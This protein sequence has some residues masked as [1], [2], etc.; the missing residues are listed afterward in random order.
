LKRYFGTDGVR[1]VA[2]SASGHG[3]TAEFALKLGQAAGRWLQNSGGEPKVV[4]GRDTRRSGPMLEGAL[5]AGFNSVG[6]S[7]TNLGV[8][9][10]PA[11]A[12][13][14]RVGGFGLGGIVSASHNPAED[15]GI[16]FVDASG[17][18]LPDTAEAEIEALLEQP[19]DRPTGGALGASEPDETLIQRYLAHLEAIVPERLHGLDIA[20]D[21]AH[22]AAYQLGPE[23]LRRLG[24]TVRVIG[25]HPNG[26][27]INAEGG[28]T[29]PHAISEFTQA[30]KA[31]VGIAFDGDA[32]RAIACDHLGRLINGDR[33]MAAW[34]V[35]AQKEGRLRVPAVVGTVMSN[36]GLEH[37]LQANAIKLER[38]DVGDKY[39]AERLKEL[40]GQIGGEQ[41]GHII[42]PAHGPTGDGLATM[43][44]FL[45]VLQL[46][47]EPAS[48]WV[49][50]YE[51]WPQLLLNLKV[52]Q[53]K[54]FS[55][56]PVVVDAIAEAQSSL[57]GKGRVNVRASG[58][59]P[60]LR[61]MVEAESQDDR[62][63]WAARI[64]AA[65]LQ[66]MGGEVVG[67]VD[68]THSL[69]D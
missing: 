57:E 64:E 43:L 55:S 30:T 18:K 26:D 54:T 63:S 37:F 11:V 58:T 22:G 49:D 32:D 29:K 62:D 53:P 65:I 41:S 39:V 35:T 52:E 8:A 36:G 46:T 47:G 5:A 45:R 19:F 15:N 20:V 51:P 3:L 9:P 28:A 6:V 59:Q 17:S 16:K 60:V 69:G 50:A 21:A 56:R 14:A 68:L 38:T 25:V 24:A 66:S 33:I 2:N 1:G 44:E 40:G 13:A 7:V 48:K 4:L 12:F 67:R 42:F 27:N 10:T 61:V 23:V 34:A 31:R